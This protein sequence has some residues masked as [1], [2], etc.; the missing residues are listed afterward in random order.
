MY[1]PFQPNDFRSLLLERKR[2]RES[3]AMSHQLDVQAHHATLT[4]EEAYKERVRM[5]AVMGIQSAQELQRE[6]D[7]LRHKEHVQQGKDVKSKVERLLGKI[8][9]GSIGPVLGGLEFVPSGMTAGGHVLMATEKKATKPALNGKTSSTILLRNLVSKGA[10]DAQLQ[11]DLQTEC[12]RFG[13]I[14]GLVI[15]QLAPTHPLS[16]S[17][18]EAVRVFVRYDSVASAFKA[19]ENLNGRLFDDRKVVASFYSTTQFDN[20]QYEDEQPLVESMI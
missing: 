1:D 13:V 7:D 6:E 5:S 11:L 18:T 14:R 9:E 17:N 10:V 2:L 8:G 4:P 12:S 3:V 16:S 19:A 20:L 15:H